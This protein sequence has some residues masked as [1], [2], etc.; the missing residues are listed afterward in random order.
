MY[1]TVYEQL[2]RLDELYGDLLQLAEQKQPVLQ[3]N[4]D[5][6][7]LQTM[8]NREEALV[9][10]AAETERRRIQAV[11]QIA[12]A[13][14]MAPETLDIRRLSET[15]PEGLG[16][17]I[18]EK[19]AHLQELLKRLRAQNEMNRQLLEINLSFAAFFMDMVSGQN[20][21]IGSI[22]GAS[23]NEAEA[24]LQSARILDSEI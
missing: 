14:R 17:A 6:E 19:G 16:E 9:S 21:G 3:Q 15:A 4:R 11:E 5:R 2:C 10:E 22:Y 20:A 8:T 1:Q 12:S 7:A 23:G 24:A 13:L 18:L